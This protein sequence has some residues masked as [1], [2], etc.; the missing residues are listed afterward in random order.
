MCYRRVGAKE[1]RAVR[2]RILRERALS[3]HI[4]LSLVFQKMCYACIWDIGLCVH[5][6]WY[7]GQVEGACLP[8]ISRAAV[9]CTQKSQVSQRYGNRA[10]IAGRDMES[11][12]TKAYE[13]TRPSARPN[14]LTNTA[15]RHHLESSTRVQCTAFGRYR[16]MRAM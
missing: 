4:V 2:A 14:K 8:Y 11:L 12:F 9:L 5:Y 13:P 3:R 10:Y 16:I 7:G 1:A 6:V 15:G